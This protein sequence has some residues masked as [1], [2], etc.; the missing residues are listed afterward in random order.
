MAGISVVGANVGCTR[1]P[2]NQASSAPPPSSY[3]KMQ[4]QH[5]VNI[6]YPKAS[7]FKSNE[8]TMTIN[9][10]T[11]RVV[12]KTGEDGI[13]LPVFGDHDHVTGSITLDPQNCAAEFGRLTV[14]I[15][16]V[17]E[18]VSPMSATKA[19]PTQITPGKYRHIFYKDSA[20][21]PLSASPRT[22]TRSA[23]RSAMAT[24]RRVT[25]RERILRPSLKRARSVETGLANSH[26]HGQSC[27]ST[28]SASSNS[29]SSSG[30]QSDRTSVTWSEESDSP[31]STSSAS[32]RTFN[33]DF[34]LCRPENTG[35][36]LPPTFSL[37]NVVSAG[38]RGRVYSENADVGY[39]VRALW[40]SLDGNNTQFQSSIPYFVVFTTKPRSR[41]LA[42]EIMA[43]ATIAVSLVRR[44]GFDKLNRTSSFDSVS[45]CTGKES[46]ISIAPKAVA[47]SANLRSGSSAKNLKKGIRLDTS[48]AT[49]GM[50][51]SCFVPDSASTPPS[52]FS[53][54]SPSSPLMSGRA[55]LLKL[56]ARSAP[57]ILSGFR[58]SRVD[59]DQESQGSLP[60]ASD[61]HP[62]QKPLPQIP[63][64]PYPPL[65]V[66]F[67][68]FQGS[69]PSRARANT[70][71]TLPS[72]DLAQFQSTT[73][74]VDV[75]KNTRDAF[76]DSQHMIHLSDSRTLHT[77]VSIGFPKRPKGVAP[78]P[79]SHP[80][81]ETVSALPDG[82]YKGCIPLQRDWFPSVRWETLS[83]EYYLQVSVIFDNSEFKGQVP[84]RLH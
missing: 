81:L 48:P 67:A 55:K 31:Y 40:E 11:V 80:S 4:L 2:L 42:A 33:F 84:L 1:P 19:G 64:G 62:A 44:V 51:N 68:P 60:C 29:S 16:G 66:S 37:S 83:I 72:R 3:K 74:I 52:S 5:T 49:I 27:S 47:S 70:Q 58:F 61:W 75:Q 32:P 53:D 15:E 24:L 8:L 12:R 79:G 59:P 46:E 41:T 77:D 82:L 38:V 21:I 56:V 17:F 57:P 54:P 45:G 14:T 76:A 71:P 6:T 22:P 13:R 34:E 43:D 78:S 20:V 69:T 50:R 39:R 23:L 9:S 30:C 7:V 18:Y 36:E 65:P 26:K 10:Q 35:D 73:P 25:S 28:S 63:Q